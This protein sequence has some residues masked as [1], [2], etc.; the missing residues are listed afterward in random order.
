[1]REARLCVPLQRAHLCLGS[2][3]GAR[4]EKKETDP[5]PLTHKPRAAYKALISLHYKLQSDFLV[6]NGP[7]PKWPK[8][9]VLHW[10]SKKNPKLQQHKQ[11]HVRIILYYYFF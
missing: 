10:P 1:M 4:S 5:S 8:H 2:D 9:P 7:V 3:K 11:K 6:K